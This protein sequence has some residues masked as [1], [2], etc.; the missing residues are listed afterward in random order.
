MTKK[1][2]VLLD[3]YLHDNPKSYQREIVKHFKE[4]YGVG[5]HRSTISRAIKEIKFKRKKI[6]Y[7][8]SQQ[9]KLLPQF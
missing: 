1:L 9:K 8:Y 7:R 3:L 2:K 6:S 4:E 5:P